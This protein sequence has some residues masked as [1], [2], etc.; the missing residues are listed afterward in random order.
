MKPRLLAAIGAGIVAAAALGWWRLVPAPPAAW[1]GY[2]EADYVDVAPLTTGR[3]TK[4][5]VARGDRVAAGAPLFDLDD[6]NERAARAAAL[7]GLAQARATLANLRAPSRPD[8]IAQDA[9]S[10]AAQRAARDQ[11]ADNLARDARVMSSGAV[12]RQKLE[13]ERLA[14]AGAQALVTVARAKLALARAPTGRAQ[15]I[16]AAAAAC[17]A[18]RATLAQADWQLAQRHVMAPAAA[19]VSD[20]DATVGETVAAG[21]TVVQLLPP[22]NIRVRFFIPEPDLAAIRF[23]AQLA[24]RC[25]GCGTGLTARVG[26]IAPQ[27]E[28]TPPVIYS[29]QSR[30]KLVYLIDATPPA[31]EALRLKPGEPVEVRPLIVPAP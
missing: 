10:L 2:A 13:Q 22:A 12:S 31:A 25:D 16:A 18:A 26:F 4:L 15:Q 14:L 21:T 20:T 9:G 30:A 29:A 17:A 3:I 1:P 5:F 19:I 6:T 7:A 8:E 23:G 27:P 28:Y 24:V 11:A